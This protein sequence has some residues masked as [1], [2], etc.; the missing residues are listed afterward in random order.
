[1]KKLAL[2]IATSAA[3]GGAAAT[4]AQAHEWGGGYG[5]GNGYGY[6]HSR[7][8]YRG[9]YRGA[10]FY[11]HDERPAVRVYERRHEGFHHHHHD[12][13]DD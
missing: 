13:F 12:D 11:R 5:Y 4:S 2:I 1:M 9:G 10:R 7:E 3:L 6:G 8:V